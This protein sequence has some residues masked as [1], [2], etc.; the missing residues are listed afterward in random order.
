MG[1]LTLA[2]KLQTCAFHLLLWLTVVLNW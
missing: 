2:L 1:M